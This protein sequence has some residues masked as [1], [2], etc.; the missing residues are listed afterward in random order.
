MIN[1]NTSVH[2]HEK[3]NIN[4]DEFCRRRCCTAAEREAAIDKIRGITPQ[5]RGETVAGPPPPPNV[6][7]GLTEA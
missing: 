7:P 1:E 5:E 3:E 2:G 6:D 4:R